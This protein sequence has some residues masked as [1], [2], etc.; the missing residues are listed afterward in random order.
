M[1]L[2]NILSDLTQLII[3]S[4]SSIDC[5]NELELATLS[6]ACLINVLACSNFSI[7]I[8]FS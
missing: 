4:A 2:K 5:S 6:A 7:F 1:S 3:F 8:S